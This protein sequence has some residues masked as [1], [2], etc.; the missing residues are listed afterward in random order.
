MTES[1]PKLSQ[2]GLSTKEATLRLARDG[3]NALPDGEHRTLLHIIWETAREPMFL[4]LLAAGTLY[5]VFGEPLE[6]ITLFAAVLVMLGLTMYQEG[7]TERAMEALRDLTSP[8]ARVIRDG[9]TIRIA[10]KDVVEGDVMLLAE[11]DRVPADGVLLEANAVQADESLLTGEPVPVRKIVAATDQTAPAQ[12]GGDDL[13]FVYSGT[14]IVHGQ[15]TA[16]VTAT[17]PRSAIGRIGTS[18]AAIGTERSPLQKQTAIL[19]RNLALLAFCL[20]LGLVAIYGFVRGDWLQA[21]LA[22]IA[23]AMALLPEEYPVV[24]TVFPALGA[25]R[26]SKEKVLTRRINA[27]ET[28]GATSVLCADKTGTL[29]ENRMT[30]ARLQTASE[31]LNVNYG[32]TAEL[33]EPFHPLVEYTILA[34]AVDPFDPMEKAFHRLGEHFLADTE[35]IHRDWTIA[36]GYG[37][38]PELKA[39]AQVWS[40]VDGAGHVVAAKGAPEAIIDLCHL[41]AAA[42]LRISAQVDAMARDGLRV[43]GVAEARHAGEDWPKGEHDF[44]F[45]FVGLVG[46]SDPIRAEIPEAIRQCD[47]AGIRVIMITGD[48]PA[49][50][51]AIAAQAGLKVGG[52]TVLSGDELSKLSD[53]ELQARLKTVS[54]CAR[55]APEQKLRIVQALKADGE[56]VAMTGDGVNDA[57]ALKA[58]HVGIA[59]GGRGTDVARESASLVLL[60]DNFAS[61]VRAIRLGRRIFDNLQKSMSYLLAVHVPIAGI[62]LLPV[63]F[64]WPTMLFPL[65]IAFLELVIDPACSLAFENEPAEPDIMQQPPRSTSAQL[66]GGP[67]LLFALIQGLGALAAVAGAYWWGLAHLPEPQARAFAFCTLVIANLALILSNRSQHGSLLASL[68][69]PNKTL[70]IVTGAALALLAVVIEV[71][72]LFQ[73]FRFDTPPPLV[74]MAVVGLGVLSAFWFELVRWSRAQ[75]TT[76]K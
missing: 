76:R 75:A 41:D 3:E 6:G 60:D 40:A 64:G 1:P 18:L 72:V 70:W 47:E 10:G 58:A 65:H 66:F 21:A 32:A 61:I 30:V 39:M 24:M 22:G 38:T 11:G 15:A 71:P 67:T 16:R 4:L 5:L 12:P 37:L 56:I 62:A 43:L 17:G 2:T 33:P 35:H 13:P 14:L 19:V 53:T 57:P 63:L 23:L 20:S 73:L 28:L 7:K 59:M 27:I 46:L 31:L 49:T 8:Q 45:T 55:I 34:S 54:V 50:A 52:G 68:R 25:W 51:H 36:H 9:Q 42:Q 48:Y 26:L 69:R 44:A 74:L 29:T